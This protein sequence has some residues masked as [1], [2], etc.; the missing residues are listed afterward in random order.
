MTQWIFSGKHNTNKAIQNNTDGYIL[1]ETKGD[2]EQNITLYKSRISINDFGDYIIIVQNDFGIFLRI[3]H[4]D[5]RSKSIYVNRILFYFYP[6]LG[7]YA[8]TI[9]VR[10]TEIHH[11]S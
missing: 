7:S 9:K 5:S 6:V 3:Y 4:V 8:H 2:I 11:M 10:K 1:E